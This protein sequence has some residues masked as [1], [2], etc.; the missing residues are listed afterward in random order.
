MFT[1]LFQHH[2]LQ[3]ASSFWFTQV[4][5][6]IRQVM[7]KRKHLIFKC[8]FDN[9]NNLKLFGFNR[10]LVAESANQK[11]QKGAPPQ[12]HFLWRG[13]EG[14][15][16]GWDWESLLPRGESVF[17][18]PGPSKVWTEKMDNCGK[19]LGLGI[20]SKI[21]FDPTSARPSPETSSIPS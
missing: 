7:M 9:V 16:L 13:L 3:T 15:L 6:F 12:F 21:C 14:L 18:V 19:P 10:G 20:I 17:L 1:Q 11:F 5:P 4:L 8:T 2:L